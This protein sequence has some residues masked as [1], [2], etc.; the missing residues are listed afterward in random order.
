MK[1]ITCF[2]YKGGAGR[3]TAAA[4]IAAA[5]ASVSAEG[6][7]DVP[8]GRKTALIDL[9]MFSAGTHRVFEIDNKQIEN[10]S[11]TNRCIQDYLCQQVSP[12]EYASRDGI[13]P[14]HALMD[15]FSSMRGGK[16]CCHSEFTLF[17]ARAD[18]DTKFVV[19]K[20]HENLLLSLLIELEKKSPPFDYVILDGESGTRQMAEIGLRLADIILV[21]FRLTW[22][23]VEGT[24]KAVKKW[25]ENPKFK[26]VYLIPTCVPLI[27]DGDNVYQKEAPGLADLRSATRRIPEL[28][29]L[30]AYARSHWKDAGHFWADVSGAANRLCIHESLCLKG[31]ERIIVFDENAKNDRAAHELYKIAAE[32]DKICQ[33]PVPPE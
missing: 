25:Q 13:T 30:D 10:F 19:Q 27:D 20:L 1:V 33:P 21:F 22:Q 4:N 5:L 28:S 31:E 8:L 2:S 16:T 15:Y 12:A 14:D 11:K 17:P 7:I 18:P 6:S 23:H 26:P 24:L 32:I 3:T 9:D 29:E